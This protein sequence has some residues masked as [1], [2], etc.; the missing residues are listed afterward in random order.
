M[1]PSHIT[2]V[3][4]IYFR[5][6]PFNTPISVHHD[7][8]RFYGGLCFYRCARCCTPLSQQNIHHGQLTYSV[9]SYP[10][11][12]FHI[13]G[14]IHFLQNQPVKFAPIAYVRVNSPGQVPLDSSSNHPKSTGQVRSDSFKHHPNQPHATLPSAIMT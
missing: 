14:I 3:S 2:G 4:T 5:T 9:A 7:R 13:R 8:D 10:P 1:T 6:P 11:F 12:Q